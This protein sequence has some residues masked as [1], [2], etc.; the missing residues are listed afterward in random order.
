MDLHSVYRMAFLHTK[1][2][3]DFIALWRDEAALGKLIQQGLPDPAAKS[4]A[5]K[6]LRLGRKLVAC[7]LAAIRRKHRAKKIASFLTHQEQYDFMVSLFRAGRVFAVRGDLT[8]ACTLKAIGAALRRFSKVVGVLYVSNC[9][10]YFRDLPQSYR[11]NMVSLPF[12][13]KSL[14][15]RTRPWRERVEPPTASSQ[16]SLFYGPLRYTYFYQDFPTM[17]L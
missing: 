2:P 16:K 14:V 1:T 12:G 5:L 10:E 13:P 9:E 17:R 7:K 6:A 3:N 4:K 15:L 8:A 11:D